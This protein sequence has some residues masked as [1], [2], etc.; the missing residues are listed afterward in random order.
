MKVAILEEA[1]Y[2]PAMR[3]LS[4]SFRQPLDKMPAVAV[5]LSKKGEPHC[6]FMRQMFVWVEITARWSWWKQMATYRIGVET[7]SS[8]T[9]HTIMSR[10]LE[11][12]DFGGE[13]IPRWFIDHL[14][15]Y[16][17]SRN[18][19]KVIDHLPGCYLYT[20]V[21]SISYSALREIV[22]QRRG[23]KHPD[24]D[25]FIGQILEQIEYPMLVEF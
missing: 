16:I 7:Q 13:G 15:V 24:W 2:W 1:G 5:H 6:K 18:F 17:A 10:P 3:G 23:H 9:M 11:M 14:N 21:L 4:L 12:E 25:L 19:E 8:S 22:R 20:R